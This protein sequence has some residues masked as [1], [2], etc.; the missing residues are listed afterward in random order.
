MI[1]GFSKYGKGASGPAL[2]YLTGYLVN[3]ETRDPKPEILRGSP[4]AVAEITDS[5]PF[6]CRY[7]SGVLSFAA[8]DRVTPVIQEE[9]M[10]RFE[11]TVFAGI[12]PDRRC[13]VWIKHTDKGRTEIHFFSPRVDL[14]T[15]RALNLAPPTPASRHLLDTLREAVNRRYGFRDPSDPECARKVSLPSHIAKLAAQAKR[16]GRSA[17]VDIRETIAERLQ[18]QAEAG[19]I[20]NRTDVIAYL[21]NQGFTIARAGLDYLTVV[22]PDTGERVR[23]KGNL[24]RENF[25]PRD[26]QRTAR[27]YDPAHLL[28]LERRL[29]RLVEKRANYH[30]ARYGVVEQTIEPAQSRE[31]MTYDRTRN[32]PHQHLQT[33]GTTIPPA[34]SIA[35]EHAGRFVEAAQRWCRAECELELAIGRVERANRAFENSLEPALTAPAVGSRIVV[36]PFQYPTVTPAARTVALHDRDD[37]FEPDMEVD[38]P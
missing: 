1:I 7:T 30:R 9:I 13:I 24:F 23:L 36:S 35:G 17:R 8:E 31:P 15:G 6:Q 14:G 11:N 37:D 28:T 21:K 22:R 25:C 26:L 38:F 27:R 10:D 19:T 20:R 4:K 5:L 12:P 16:H 32:T 29:E 2:D 3:G 18:E 33:I 34:R